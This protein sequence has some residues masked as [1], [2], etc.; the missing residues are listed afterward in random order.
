MVQFLSDGRSSSAPLRSHCS[1][2]R[3]AVRFA[4]RASADGAVFRSCSPRSSMFGDI[5]ISLVSAPIPIGAVRPCC[6]PLRPC[7]VPQ[8]ATPAFDSPLGGGVAVAKTNKPALCL[9]H[10]AS[11]VCHPVKDMF[12]S[13]VKRVSCACCPV[14]EAR[15]RVQ[16]VTLPPFMAA[17]A[18]PGFG[19]AVRKCSLLLADAQTN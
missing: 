1:H 11:K 12:S 8:V 13:C 7:C 17:N 5:Q 16:H 15:P 18:C 10:S 2:H 19:A 4:S 14:P 6:V 3:E 9:R